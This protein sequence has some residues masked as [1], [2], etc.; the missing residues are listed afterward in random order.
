L[1]DFSTKDNAR[2]LDAAKKIYEHKL[3][4]IYG[5]KTLAEKV[6]DE[7]IKNLL[8]QVYTEEETIADMWVNRIIEQGGQIDTNGLFGNMKTKILSRIL[9]TKG[10]FKW[11]LEEEE[12]GIKEL[13]LQAELIQENVQ[14]ETWSRYAG[15]EQRHL[16]RI[17]TEI[18]GMD[19]WDIQG[20]SGERATAA[21]FSGYYS[22]LLSTLSFIT[23]MF[24]ARTGFNIIFIS[25]FASIFSGS[26]ARA[27]GAYQ[28]HR[29]EMEILTRES[30]EISI[31]RNTGDEDRKQ[32]LEFYH[33]QGF[34]DDEAASLMDSINVD[35]PSNIENAIDNIGLS[36][37][38]FGNSVKVMINSGRNFAS[39][40]I[41]PILPFL[42]PSLELE[43]ALIISICGTLLC[44]FIVGA[45]KSIFTRK[46]WYKSGFE[47]VVF[48]VITSAITY[49]IGNLVSL[50][51]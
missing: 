37:T 45:A 24:G 5:F 1:S 36:S 16:H 48:G 42:I 7:I 49:T 46:K 13:A 26:I 50:I 10:F 31:N 23:G 34:S 30:K 29:S 28:R 39:A 22:G 43:K 27:G 4:K 25:G 14:S 17:R 19:S 40:A 2:L 12:A 33:S 3:E 11:V 6:D 21:L 9:G 8:I 38:Q 20:T 15:D 51:L 18:L 44:L 35:R 47:V 32:L 41:I